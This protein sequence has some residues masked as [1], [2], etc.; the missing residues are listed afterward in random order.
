MCESFG[1]AVGVGKKV[2]SFHL[3]QEYLSY[4]FH[5]GFIAMWAFDVLPQASGGGK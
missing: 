1:F 3:A 2:F 5:R 4:I